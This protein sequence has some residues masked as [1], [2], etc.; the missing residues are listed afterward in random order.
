MRPNV[1]GDE[2]GLFTQISEEKS[3][4]QRVASIEDDR[5]QNNVEEDFRIESGLRA[6]IVSAIE[7]I[8]G[9]EAPTF[10]EMSCPA[11]VVLSC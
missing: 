1:I 2:E 8:T 6:V 4:L 9:S 3:F 5:R 11:E 7:L 10:W